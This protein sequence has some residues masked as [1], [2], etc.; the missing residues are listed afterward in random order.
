ML[1]WRKK[2]EDENCPSP[3]LSL[4]PRIYE[5]PELSIISYVEPIEKYLASEPGLG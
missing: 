4:Q 3:R 5:F 2:F 1:F